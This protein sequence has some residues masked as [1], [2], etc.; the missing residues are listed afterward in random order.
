MQDL[1]L[2][3]YKINKI[4]QEIKLLNYIFLNNNAVLV[5][6]KPKELLST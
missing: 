4:E 6:P 2:I 5:P 1:L 3:K